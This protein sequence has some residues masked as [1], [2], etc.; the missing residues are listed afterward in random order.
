M[1]G[2]CWDDDLRCSGDEICGDN[3]RGDES[4]DGG[5]VCNDDGWGVLDED[6]IGDN[7]NG[8]ELL[9]LMSIPRM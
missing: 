5:V 8:C 2:I 7:E 6:S 4:S 3:D 1:K 9:P